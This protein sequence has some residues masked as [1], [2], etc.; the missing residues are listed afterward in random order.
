MILGG[1]LCRPSFLPD[2]MEQSLNERFENGDLVEMGELDF[3]R[4]PTSGAL[5]IWRG[6]ALVGLN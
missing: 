5:L 1:G 6:I 3:A 2:A 4:S